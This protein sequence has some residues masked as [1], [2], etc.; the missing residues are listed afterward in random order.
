MICAVAIGLPDNDLGQRVH[1]IVQVREGTNTA[2]LED[3]LRRFSADQIALYKTPRD[4]E[5]VTQKLRDEAGKVRRHALR[6]ERT[7]PTVNPA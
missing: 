7:G 5:F 1:A 6:E 4:Y 3:E 2:T